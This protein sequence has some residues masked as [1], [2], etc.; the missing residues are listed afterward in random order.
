MPK[1]QAR[2]EEAELSISLIVGKMLQFPLISS[3]A[4]RFCLY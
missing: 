1:Y 4:L 3:E 2:G